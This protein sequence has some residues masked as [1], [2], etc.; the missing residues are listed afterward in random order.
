MFF[1]LG[2]VNVEFQAPD[3]VCEYKMVLFMNP[4]IN[5]SQDCNKFTFDSKNKG[6]VVHSSEKNLCFSEPSSCHVSQD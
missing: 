5:N 1:R 3:L 6:V 2:V 4:A